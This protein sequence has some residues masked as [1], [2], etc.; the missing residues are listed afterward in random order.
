MSQEN[1]EITSLQHEYTFW[2]TY[3]KKT[4]DKQLEEFEDNLKPI[5]NFNNVEDFWSICQ[6]M[7]RPSQ[8]PRGC[9]FFLFKKNIKPMWED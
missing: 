2:F 8:L 9:T 7:R 6:H 3:F 4:K 5:G 1:T